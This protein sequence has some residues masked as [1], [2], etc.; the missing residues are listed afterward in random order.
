MDQVV[1][2]EVEIEGEAALSGLV[3]I[4]SEWAEDGALPLS[5]F[6]QA[7]NDLELPARL[8]RAAMDVLRDAGVRIVDDAL[9]DDA[10][11]DDDVDAA[12]GRQGV[13]GFGHFMRQTAHDVLEFEQEQA[14]GVRMDAGRLAAQALADHPELDTRTRAQL[15]RM[16]RDGERAADE[17]ARHNIRLVISI[18]KKYRGQCSPGH[19]FED[20]VQE[21]YLGLV[22]AISKWEHSRGLKGPPQVKPRSVVSVLWSWQRLGWRRSSRR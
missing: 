17:L 10:A 22:H 1:L 2:A 21:G 16:V 9:T 19:D 11:G 3:A 18:A 13:D 14:L 20:L 15:R 5:R 6:T 4:A 12:P 7:V 8:Y